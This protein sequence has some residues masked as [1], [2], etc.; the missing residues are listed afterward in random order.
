MLTPRSG[1]VGHQRHTSQR[2]LP[3]LALVA[4]VPVGLVLSGAV[5]AAD[6]AAAVPGRVLYRDTGFDPDDVPIDP[7]SCCQQDPDIQSSTRTVTISG[8]RRTLF[9]TFRTYEALKGYWTVNA[10][11]D[12][13]GG[14]LVD[15][16]MSIHD[17]GLGPS[18]C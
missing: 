14:P 10:R 11:L 2:S 12:T 17:S 8:A 3:I 15:A 6:P 1:D 16:G 13:R 5:I 9:I 4:A 18:G 7:G